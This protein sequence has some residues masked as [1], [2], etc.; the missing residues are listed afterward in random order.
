[1]IFLLALVVHSR[2]TFS[3]RSFVALYFIDQVTSYD[4]WLSRSE[5]RSGTLCSGTIPEDL[6]CCEPSI[7]MTKQELRREMGRRL[8]ELST[9]YI[10]AQSGLASQRIVETEAWRRAKGIACFCSMEKEFQTTDLIKAA[11]SE[12]KKVYLPKVVSLKSRSMIFR[13]A[14]SI[15]EIQRYPRSKWG[16]PEPPEGDEDLDS[17]DLVIVPAVAFDHRCAR[18]GHGAGFYDTFIHRLPTKR[19][20]LFGV[21]LDEQLL[22]DSI[23]PVEPHD[24]PLDAV[25]TP[26]HHLTSSS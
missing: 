19:R 21:A 6:Q 11:F 18:L 9:E 23:L 26:S 5:S 8:S 25:F 12:N 24:V 22:L 13:Q 14:T 3:L 15:E 1:M 17:I 20:P 16:I 2:I 7:E 10:A 4:S